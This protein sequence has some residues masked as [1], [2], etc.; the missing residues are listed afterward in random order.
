MATLCK[1]PAK[2]TDIG[3]SIMVVCKIVRKKML[4]QDDYFCSECI[5]SHY[6][7]FP[8]ISSS[9]LLTHYMRCQIS[10]IYHSLLLRLK[11]RLRK[12]KTETYAYLKAG[13]ET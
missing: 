1:A 9:C 6:L 13:Q 8:L 7:R 12:G 4:G 2:S 11:S 3:L 10:C 5:L